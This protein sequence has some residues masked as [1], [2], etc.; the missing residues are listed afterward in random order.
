MRI[1][2][3][4]NLKCLL[5]AVLLCSVAGAGAADLS[6]VYTVRPEDPEA[7][8]FTYENYGVKADGKM[9]VSDILQEA[10]YQVKNERNFGILFIPEGKYKISRTIYIPTAVRIIGYGEKR[11]EFI[12]ARNSPGFQEPVAADKGKARYMFWFT[13]GIVNDEKNVGDAGASTFYSCMSNINLRIEDGNPNAIALRTHYAQ[14]SFISHMAVYAGKAKAGLFDCGNEMSNIAFF[15]GDYGIYT[16]K[17]SPGWPVAAVDMYFEGQ[18][19]AAL[20]C[21]ES[22]L[23]MVNLHVKNVPVVFELQENYA[24]RLS[25]DGA[26]FENVSGPAII[27]ANEDNSNNQINFRDIYCKNVPVLAKFRR[28]GKEVTLADKA[29]RISSFTHGFVMAD[30]VSDAEF[31]TTLETE[32]LKKL[33]EAAASVLPSIPDI[34]GCVNLRDLGAKGDGVTDDTEIIQKAIDTYENI[35]V[36]AGWYVVSKTLK[37]RPGT[38]L[39]GLHPFA[40]QFKLLESTP[41]FSGFGSPVA[42]VESSEG[43]DDILSGIGINTGA[44]NYR[45]C[46][47]KWMAGAD[48]YLNDVKFV[49]GH[50]SLRK[51]VPASAQNT[52]RSSWNGGRRISSP[53]SPVTETGKDLAWDRQYYSLWVTNG[54]GGTFKDIWTASTYAVNG[55]YVE[56]TSTPGNVYAMSVEH[57]VINE[58]RL[59]KVQNWKFYCLQTEEESRE[60][61]ECQPVEMDGCGNVEFHNTYMFRVIRVNEPYHSSVRVRNCSN[62]RFYNLHNYSQIKYTTDIPVFD[63]NKN[64]EVRPWELARLDVT[65]S[66]PSRRR[67]E[68][69]VTEIARDFDFTEGIASDSKGNVYFCDNR[70]HRIYRIDAATRNL[71]LVA[72]FHWKPMSLA[73][74]T[75]DNL[76]V[77][78]RYEAQPGFEA[79]PNKP[80]AL[81]DTKGTS[82]SGY[83]NAGYSSLFYTM[84]VNNPEETIQLLPLV[85]HK[86]VKNVAKAFYASNRW[87]DFHDFNT[88]VVFKP[89]KCFLA[90][91][92]RTIIPQQYDLARTSSLLPAYPGRTFYCSDEYDKRIVTCDVLDDGTLTNL[93]YHIEYGEFGVAEDKEGNLYVADGEILVF[94]RSGK[95]TGRINVP[96]RP[97]TIVF[98]GEDGTSLFVTGRKRVFVTDLKQ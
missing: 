69:G 95:M 22:G 82:F 36:P 23:A 92:G 39:I 10:I 3:I 12:L 1:F 65:G 56:N 93:T 61:T 78:F 63:H 74:D 30:M 57:H 48:S 26:R 28:S 27:V 25:I 42:L 32:P 40:T 6:S 89:E 55:V 98:G 97:S 41:A 13:R 37:L 86:S 20:Y 68:D 96:E 67:T 70:L 85:E 52:A 83:G 94:D 51:P 87:R 91:D 19:K 72:D 29:C 71:S 79:E 33:P 60:S 4:R 18:R 84:D 16:T 43:G 35:Y 49:G 64:I 66:E 15:G 62:V 80:F 75:E 2:N 21:Q 59:N 14:H 53:E 90:P 54:G 46:G 88:V 58:V 9:D 45:A 44:Y 47:I 76:L 8:Y 24:D 50:G 81:P 5:A 31:V 34:A 77:L 73:F 38:K 7:F 11:P 17:A